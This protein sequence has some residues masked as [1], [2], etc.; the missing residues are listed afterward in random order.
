MSTNSP[1]V[2]LEA[3][4]VKQKG[5]DLTTKIS[6]TGKLANP[7][8]DARLMN[9]MSGP[10][11]AKRLGLSRQYV[12]RAE[13]GTYTS[14]NPALLRWVSN[15]LSITVGGVEK[16]YIQF[17]KASRQATVEKVNPHKLI[18][19]PGNLDPGGL[20]FE[21]W[22]SGYWPSPTAFAVAFCVHSDLV[23]KYE[24]GITK[25]IPKQIKEA[26]LENQLIDENWID[27]PSKGEA[28]SGRVS[29]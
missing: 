13:Q 2:K 18:R 9:S 11:L 26:L 24:E 19:N 1:A 3:Q 4:D 14:L 27:E 22:R 5:R 10:M 21:R 28:L 29:A 23:S 6:F 17:Q 15:A 16:R 7:V 20:L 8:T 12:N 25:T